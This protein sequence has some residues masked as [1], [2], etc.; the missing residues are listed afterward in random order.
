MR[1]FAWDII[2][3]SKELPVQSQK[4]KHKYKVWK[5]FKIENEDTWTILMG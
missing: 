4:L 3:S 1:G 5:L 2:R